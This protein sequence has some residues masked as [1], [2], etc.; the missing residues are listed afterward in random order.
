M[1]AIARTLEILEGNR[2]ARDAPERVFRAM[3]ERTLWARGSLASEDMTGGIP[4]GAEKHDPT[5]G[6]LGE[7]HRTLELAPRTKHH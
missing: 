5:S 1:E 6:I 4:E 7:R 2:T 3:V